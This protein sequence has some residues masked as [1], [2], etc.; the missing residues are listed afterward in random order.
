MS[1]EEFTDDIHISQ[2]LPFAP[3]IDTV[4]VRAGGD[5]EPGSDA[6]VPATCQATT[7]AQ[8]VPGLSPRYCY[9]RTGNPTRDRLE[10]ALAQLEGARFARS[11]AS[12]LAA[13]D[14]LLHTLRA[15]DHVVA[16]QDLYGGCWRQFTKVWSKFDVRF[17]FVDATDVAAVA[18]A[19]TPRTKL[20][21]LETPSN[22]LLRVTPIA[23]VCAIARAAGVRTVVDNTFAT[24]LLQRPLELGADIVLHSTTK[25]IGGHCDVLGGALVTDDPTIAQE[26]AFLQN[27]LGAVPSPSDCT[28]LLRGI[29]T[30][31]LRVERHCA[32]ALTIARALEGTPGVEAVWYPGLESH[33]GHAVAK[34]QMSAFGGIVTLQLA[35]GRA[36]VD[37][38]ARASRL[39]TLA[40]S[41]GGF[42]SLLCHPPTMTHAS[43][44]Q[45]ER[46]RIGITEGTVRLSVGLEDARDL[47][48]DLRHAL[49]AASVTR[50]AEVVR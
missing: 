47:L 44:E 37:A 10:Q 9:G 30:L 23:K 22:P 7:F 17:T 32:S 5:P 41:L 33:D 36:A 43:V 1:H 12:G 29:R 48:A 50:Q 26:V 46:E 19:I 3:S 2:D 16:S 13:V 40:E 21:W 25:Y 45:S 38:F 42:K 15:G 14:T 49:S 31:S 8:S 34:Q 39:W 4:C 27:A 28:L 35:G 20:L 18:A 6:L 11:F 24:P